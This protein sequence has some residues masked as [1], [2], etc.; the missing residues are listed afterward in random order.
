MNISRTEFMA[1]KTIATFSPR[2]QLIKAFEFLVKTPGSTGL[3]LVTHIQRANVW[4]VNKGVYLNTGGKLLDYWLDTFAPEQTWQIFDIFRRTKNRTGINAISY[5]DKLRLF[6][7]FKEWVRIS[8]AAMSQKKNQVLFDLTMS[9]EWMGLSK[10]GRDVLSKSGALMKRT[11]YALHKEKAVESQEDSLKIV[12]RQNTHVIKIDNYNHAYATRRFSANQTSSYTACNWATMALSKV[13]V[14]YNL[15]RIPHIHIS[16]DD[17]DSGD[18]FELALNL[19]AVVSED[20]ADNVLSEL[21]EWH[22]QIR[23]MKTEDFVCNATES[24][25]IPVQHNPECGI[26]E[27]TSLDNFFPTGL[28]DANPGADQGLESIM[29]HFYRLYAHTGPTEGKIGSYFMIC[30]DCN[31]YFRWV[32]VSGN[33]RA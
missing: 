19:E 28:M 23:E 14:D 30:M 18:G 31:I 33:F 29:K 20:I 10:D 13:E 11:A 27:K 16:L 4:K 15:G 1:P 22:N 12:R 8:C 3:Q 21:V 5:V 32:K 7:K 24:F 17:E 2:K 25:L 9:T 26:E 6:D